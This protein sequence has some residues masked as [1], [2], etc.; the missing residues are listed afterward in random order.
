M[1]HA[2]YIASFEENVS[3][4]NSKVIPRHPVID[5]AILLFYPTISRSRSDFVKHLQILEKK[6]LVK[7]DSS[8]NLALK[9]GSFTFIFFRHIVFNF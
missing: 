7:Y 9:F 2:L 1:Q 6:F 3:S 8:R 4:D 5:A